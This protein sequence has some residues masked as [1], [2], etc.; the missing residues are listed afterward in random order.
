[1]RIHIDHLKESRL[2]LE[3]EKPADRFPAL[4]RVTATGDDNFTGPVRTS[5]T[6]ERVGE[7]VEIRGVVRA[8]ARQSCGRCLAEFDSLVETEFELTYAR[9]GEGPSG[10]A[11]LPRSDP[12]P[13]DGLIYFYGDEIDLTAGVQEHLI[14]SLPLK[15]LCREDC[16][17]LCV[18][19]GSDLNLGPCT[20]TG[21]SDDGPFETLRR[22]KLPK[23][24]RGSGS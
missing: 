23:I 16:K 4:R 9:R 20:C 12:A 14:L 3:F 15:P 21:A 7:L 10:A 22:L 13:D 24:L 5:V 19:C 1:M 18:R 17:G 11:D 2:T 6:A 8:A